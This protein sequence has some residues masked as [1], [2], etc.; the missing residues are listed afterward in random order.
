MDF[1][2]RTLLVTGM[3]ATTSGCA[4]AG[5]PPKRHGDAAWPGF[6]AAFLQPDGRIVDTG[7]GG[8]SHSEGQGYALLLAEAGDDRA[9]FD[10]IHQ[11]TEQML[12]RHDVALFSWRY[13][14][15]AAVPV[16]DT[17]NA[18][19]GDILIAWALLRAGQRWQDKA[20]LAR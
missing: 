18:S 19:D 20:L 9:A 7:N 2:R 16:G 14:P 6:K 1:D 8:I 10:R 5:S 17:N 13:D 11:W 15:R 3:I 12:A 4:K